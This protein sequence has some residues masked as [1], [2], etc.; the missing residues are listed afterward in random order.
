MAWYEDTAI[1]QH[2]GLESVL[3]G[4]QM[5]ADVADHGAIMCVVSRVLA[6]GGL[7]IACGSEPS[8]VMQAWVKVRLQV[9]GSSHVA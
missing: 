1:C 7:L 2:I 4:A 8:L 3:P 9:G 5:V 6:F